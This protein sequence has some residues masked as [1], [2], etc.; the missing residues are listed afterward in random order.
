M[1]RDAIENITK[2]F[3]D[4]PLAPVL[5]SEAT[6]LAGV[7]LNQL[8]YMRQ[9]KRAE[10]LFHNAQDLYALSF[11]AEACGKSRQW[12]MVRA[13]IADAVLRIRL[14]IEGDDLPVDLPVDHRVKH[15]GSE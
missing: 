5:D 2:A 14:A 13:S 3:E 10:V 7:A 15:H 11:E 1:H 8:N 9:C 12:S 6:R 4:T